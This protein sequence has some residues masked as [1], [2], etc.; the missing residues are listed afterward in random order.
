MKKI[1]LIN[2]N[3]CIIYMNNGKSFSLYSGDE[4]ILLFLHWFFYS[5]ENK[6]IQ[7]CQLTL[8][9][10]SDTVSIELSKIA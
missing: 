3:E 4:N 5:K 10:M 9:N 2:D 6:N 7:D 8:N 1:K